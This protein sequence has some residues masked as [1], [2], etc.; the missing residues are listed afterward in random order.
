MRKTGFVRTLFCLLLAM[1][2]LITTILTTSCQSEKSGKVV[3]STADF[4]VTDKMMSYFIY[5]VYQEHVE[6]FKSMLENMGLPDDMVYSY[7]GIDPNSS[8]KKQ[9]RDHQN[10]Q[11]WFDYFAEQ[12]KEQAE[13]LLIICQAAKNAGAALSEDEM[14]RIDVQMGM[15]K[16]Y[17]KNK[18][19]SNLDSYLSDIYGNGVKEEDVRKALELQTYASKYYSMVQDDYHTSATLSDVEAFFD[20]NKD[21]Y[22]SADYYSYTFTLRMSDLRQ[23]EENQNKSEEE[24]EAIY[25]Q[26]KTD[27]SAKAN[28][29]LGMT[30]LD[31]FLTCAKEIW[32]EDN[33]D[34]L[35]T[36]YYEEEIGWVSDPTTEEKTTAAERAENRVNEA[37]DAY[38]EGLL[39]KEYR[40][41]GDA[42]S[43]WIFGADGENPALVNSTR[44][45]VNDSFGQDEVYYAT[46]YFVVRAASRVEDTTRNFSYVLF[47]IAQK[48]T[49]KAYTEAQ[50]KAIFEEFKTGEKTDAEALQGLEEKWNITGSE[51]SFGQYIEARRSDFGSSVISAGKE[52]GTAV[53]VPVGGGSGISSGSQSVITIIKDL[54]SGSLNQN[55]TSD[56]L[57]FV[58]KPIDTTSATNQ[59]VPEEITA[60]LFDDNRNAGDFELIQY[61][62]YNAMTKMDTAYYV[63]LLIDEIGPEEW[64][65]D[66]RDG[67]VAEQMGK[68]YEKQMKT[69]A[70]SVDQ[71]AINNIEM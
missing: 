28:A 15:L 63:I 42:L 34:G 10:G 22:I 70:V 65:I 59:G 1:C 9:V 56:E 62:Q 33:R 18:S 27:L 68:W 54:L 57:D 35:Y 25:E 71:E 21:D 16:L 48:E 39:T 3:M 66:A 7:M 50:I 30:T 49:D 58:I 47:P 31:S 32:L 37:A 61:T 43:L 26:I 2:M 24:L 12:A 64:F 52:F 41:R 44:L 69:H 4:E 6:S 46:V 55:A 60:W 40:N 29:L 53:L 51:L 38:V 19:Y 8:L 11:T 13:E 36:K 17:S 67:L 14:M 23:K 5:S 45:I 20:R